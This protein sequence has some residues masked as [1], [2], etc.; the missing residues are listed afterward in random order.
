M[1]V[2]F[3]QVFLTCPLVPRLLSAALCFQMRREK[4]CVL[5]RCRTNRCHCFRKASPVAVCPSDLAYRL[6][7]N[8]F[9]LLVVPPFVPSSANIWPRRL[10]T[11]GPDSACGA[12]PH[13]LL[14]CPRSRRLSVPVSHSP[15]PESGSI[16]QR[17]VGTLFLRGLQREPHL[18]SESPPPFSERIVQ[19]PLYDNIFPR[20]HKP[21]AGE[22]QGETLGLV[23]EALRKADSIGTCLTAGTKGIEVV[24]SVFFVALRVAWRRRP[25]R[26]CFAILINLVSTVDFLV[27]FVLTEC[28]LSWKDVEDVNK[29]RSLV[30]Q[31]M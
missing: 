3:L 26:S 7:P 10:F 6:L 13:L 5:S 9:F 28:R 8:H 4:L 30:S 1:P 11:T 22:E 17:Y 29:T 21:V 16:P 15:K 24:F 19:H 23:K 25:T 20:L 27:A 31:D 12:R 14:P 2:A 18:A